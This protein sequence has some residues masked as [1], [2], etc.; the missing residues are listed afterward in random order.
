MG[1]SLAVGLAATP[2]SCPGALVLLADL[3]G[4]RAK[5]LN[6]VLSCVV[7][8]LAAVAPVRGTAPAHPVWLARQLFTSAQALHAD[9]G[10]RAVLRG[11][12]DVL[13]PPLSAVCAL[14]IDRRR[15]WKRLLRSPRLAG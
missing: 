3:P 5:A 15:D 1:T 14:D 13:R 6:Q 4:L 9:V 2:E 11:R 10:A 12:A 8:G 7:P